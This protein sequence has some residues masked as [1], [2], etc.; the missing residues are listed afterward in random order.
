MQGD[1][2]AQGVEL[3]LYGMGT[4]VVFLSLLVVITTLM[5]AIVQRYFAEPEPVAVVT[6]VPAGES[7][8]DA[9]VGRRC[10]RRHSPAQ[11]PPLTEPEV[12][13]HGTE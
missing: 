5:S 7:T 13:D 12:F 2:V 11:K 4:V 6:V 9:E 10:C 1:I 8:P 3:M